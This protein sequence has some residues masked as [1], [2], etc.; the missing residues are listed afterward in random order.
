MISC[1]MKEV[2]FMVDNFDDF[3]NPMGSYTALLL[4]SNC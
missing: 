1:S 3:F 2:V 4:E